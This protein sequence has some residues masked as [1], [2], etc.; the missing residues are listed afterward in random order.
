MVIDITK[1]KSTLDWF[2][3][4]GQN[5]KAEII[6]IVIVVA[7][8]YQVTKQELI[9]KTKDNEKRVSDSTY[10]ARLDNTHIF[11]QTEISKCNE[12]RIKDQIRQ[13]KIWQ[14]RFND[15]FIKTDKTYQ[16]INN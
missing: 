15:L 12:E 9:I 7:L 1:I 6:L 3:H 10:S 4:L 16:E 2:V 14:E 11:H 8:G 13:N 5:Y